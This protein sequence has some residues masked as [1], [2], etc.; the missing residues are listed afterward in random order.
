M[1][2]ISM[3]NK[4]WYKRIDRDYGGSISRDFSKYRNF[5][6]HF[7]DLYCDGV[8]K[9]TEDITCDNLQVFVEI[10]LKQ[11][12]YYNIKMWDI[13]NLSEC[14]QIYFSQSYQEELYP[15]GIYIIPE[16]DRRSLASDIFDETNTTDWIMFPEDVS[17]VL[18]CL[19][20]PEE[21]IINMP[22]KLDEYFEQFDGDK[23]NNI[24][25]PRRWEAIKRE[26]MEAL[27]K[28]EPLPIRPMSIE[29]DPC[30]KEK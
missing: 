28:G 22:K 2:I 11:Y 21:D 27:E 17:F 26:R 9:E 20:C 29:L 13:L 16:S 24:E 5:I 19:N 23:K 6:Q 8:F 4:L 14:I 12:Q 15:D 1:A 3:V 25:F 7:I 18:G 30:Y 10:V